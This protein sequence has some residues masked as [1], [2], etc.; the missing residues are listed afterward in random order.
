MLVIRVAKASD[1]EEIDQ[2]TKEFSDH[3]Y[4]H[5]PKYFNEAISSQKLLV[6]L[7]ENKV[8]GYL[9]YQLI[10]G[11]TPFLELMRVT[12]SQQNKGIGS[13]LLRKLEIILKKSGYKVLISSS[14]EVNEVGNAWH[15]KKRFEPIGQLKMIYGVEIFYKKE[16][17]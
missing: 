4:S 7:I 11:N 6:A 13:E 15:Q 8:V 17:F 10:W 16:I 3:E 12:L 5:S 9:T 2:I 1:R 14:E